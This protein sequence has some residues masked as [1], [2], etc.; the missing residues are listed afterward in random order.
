MN[1]KSALSG[2][3]ATGALLVALL[4][5]PG[6]SSAYLSSKPKIVNLTTT[7]EDITA[8]AERELKNF[9]ASNAIDGKAST[10]WDA[11]IQGTLVDPVTLT[12]DLGGVYEISRIQLVGGTP[13]S[14][15]QSYYRILVSKDGE[16]WQALDPLRGNPRLFTAGGGSSFIEAE[17]IRYEVLGGTKTARLAEMK[18]MG[19]QPQKQVPI[20]ATALLLGSGLP[21]LIAVSRRRSR[22]V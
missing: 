16:T 14:R 9:I 15:K 5:F 7:L 3:L 11:G 1:R 4:G 10:R 8:E 17:F 20:P 18:I 22:G 13:G 12:V 6:M 2:L 21:V 19:P